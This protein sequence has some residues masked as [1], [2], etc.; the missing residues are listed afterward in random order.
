[1]ENLTLT[2]ALALV[3]VVA[4]A[5]LFINWAGNRKTP[6]LFLIATAFSVSSTGA[7]L[8][9]TQSI[10]PA[11][12]S[13]FLA[14]CFALLGGIPLL[15]GLAKFWNQESPKLVITVIALCVLTIAG[16]YYF[17]LVSDEIMWR[18]RLFTIMIIIFDASYVYIISKGLQQERKRRPIMSVNPNF[19]AFTAIALFAFTA[20]AGLFMMFLRADSPLDSTDIGMSIFLLGAIFSV[21]VFPFVV[22][23][24]TMEEISIEHQEN[25]IFDPVTTILNHRTFIEVGQRVMGIALR[26]SK[27]VSLLTIE[28]NDMDKVVRKFGT[29][30]ANEMLRHF[31]LIATDRRRNEDVLARTSFKE[32]RMLLPGVDQKGCEVV[33]RKVN[34]SLKA[35]AFSFRGEQ[36]PISVTIAAVTRKE[37]DLNLTDML[38]E[39]EIELHRLK[40]VTA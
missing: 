32:F 15:I 25:A 31:S 8:L 4:G 10:W 2:A 37:E 14:D 19:G 39:G 16:V 20:V 34:K 28:I 6:G 33:I 26:Y 11:I 24:M 38:Q 27:P 18:I 5:A 21:V 13:V 30:V 29:N 3:S 36:V 9:A 7:L 35:E 12:V 23:I 1:M 17:T 22:I 40:L